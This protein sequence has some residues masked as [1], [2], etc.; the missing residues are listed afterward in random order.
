MRPSRWLPLLV[1]LPLLGA[2]C[3]TKS[4]IEDLRTQI[5]EREQSQEREL[6]RIAERQ[7]AIQDSVSA[8]SETFFEMRGSLGR[9]MVQVL[10]QLVTLQELTGQSQRNLAALRDRIETQRR[11]L[12][13]EDGEE[14]RDGPGGA[15]APDDDGEDGPGGPAGLQEGGGEAQELYNVAV[16]QFNRGSFATARR[17]FQQFLE[18]HPNHRLAADAHFYLADILVQEDRTEEAVE[19]F[20]RIPQRFPASRRV[21]E[22]LYRLGVLHVELDRPDEA[23]DFFERVV[24]SYPEAGVASLARE[25]LEEL[26]R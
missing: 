3:A 24:N 25:R 21:P 5:R 9:Q 12:P 7:E 6:Q 18:A 22:A 11:I 20:E 23:R 13:P 26:R 1:A 8:L 15:G 10:D 4:D 2:G 14:G 19:A 17:A 16:S